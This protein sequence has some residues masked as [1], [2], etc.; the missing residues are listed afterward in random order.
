M[1]ANE[2]KGEGPGTAQDIT[3]DAVYAEGRAAAERREGADKNPHSA[4]SAEYRRWADGHA[5]VTAPDAVADDLA[6]FA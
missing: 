1:D 6:D 2:G 4:G 3:K 5:S